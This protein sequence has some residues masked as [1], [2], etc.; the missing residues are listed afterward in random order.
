[1]VKRP[2]F[3]VGYE[4]DPIFTEQREAGDTARHRLSLNYYYLFRSRWLALTRIS[5]E[6]NREL[7]FDLRTSGDF[8][9]GRALI[10]NNRTVLIMG[11]GIQLNRERPLEGDSSTNVAAFLLVRYW[12]FFFDYP[13]TNVDAALRVLPDLTTSGRW[14][15]EADVKL[16]RE[17]LKDFY[18]SVTVLESYDSEPATPGA[19][20]NDLQATLSLGWKF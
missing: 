8:G 12:T 16:S 2:K 14:R 4:L 3:W 9:V 18:L 1:M 15:L 19:K 13:H 7:G 5:F 11:L 10:Q 17:L 6:Q 20:N